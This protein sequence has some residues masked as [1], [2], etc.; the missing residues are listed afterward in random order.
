MDEVTRK[1]K[2]TMLEKRIS[3][4]DLVR[5]TGLRKGSVNNLIRGQADSRAAREKITNFCGVQLWPDI[6]VTERR[7]TLPA[8]LEIEFDTEREAISAEEEFHGFI[9]RSGR[10]LSFIKP[11]SAIIGETESAPTSNSK[12]V[13]SRLPEAGCG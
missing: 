1:I 7:V 10:K 8:G 11:T 3:I 4:D 9:R 12:S 2:I 6:P 5:A 13:P